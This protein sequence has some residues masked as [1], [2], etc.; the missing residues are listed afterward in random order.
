MFGNLRLRNIFDPNLNDSS[1]MP[2]DMGSN[3]NPPQLGPQTMGPMPQPMQQPM[4]SPDDYDPVARMKQLYTPENSASDRLNSMIDNMPHYNEHQGK[5]RSLAAAIIAATQGAKAGSNALMAPYHHQMDEWNTKIKPVE[6]AAT[7]EKN[8]NSI[9]RQLATSTVNA[10][11]VDRRDTARQKTNEANTKIREDRANVYRF[12]VEHPDK[13]FNFTGPNVMMTDPATGE[14]TDTGVATGSLSATDKLNLQH[15]NRTSEIHTAGQEARQTEQTR[16]T[17]RVDLAGVK[18]DE[19][20]LTKETP[21]GSSSSKS[22]TPTQTK[23]RQYNAAKEFAAK[24]PDLAKFIKFGKSN[25]FTISPPVKK[26]GGFTD[27]FKG[28][29]PSEEEHNRINSAIFGSGLQVPQP[30]RSGSSTNTGGTNTPSTS[31]VQGVRVRS[32]NGQTGTFKGTVEEA[33]RAGFTVIQ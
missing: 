30:G 21:S 5:L 17:G 3:Y 19:A 25:D 24:N 14:V 10:E 23:V 13:K 16:Q 20:R 15:E 29:G 4:Q 22:E 9:N 6:N 27:Y 11:E 7:L 31:S 1:Q 18:G 28:V 32:Q 8:N 26:T 2:S 33:K 12:K